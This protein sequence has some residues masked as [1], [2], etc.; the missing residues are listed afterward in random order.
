M[1]V[2]PLEA[3][4][5]DDVMA[6]DSTVV[7]DPAPPKEMPAKVGVVCRD[8]PEAQAPEASEY[9][10]GSGEPVPRSRC[11]SPVPGHKNLQKPMI[12]PTQHHTSAY[13]RTYSIQSC[14]FSGS[15]IFLETF[16]FLLFDLSESS[17]E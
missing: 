6:R 10:K 16:V 12:F 5:V 8:S 9:K 2:V 17:H 15:A 4:G 3:K 11:F 1:V 14:A 13:L 7:E